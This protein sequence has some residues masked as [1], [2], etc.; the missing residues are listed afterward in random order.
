MISSCSMSFMRTRQVRILNTYDDGVANHDKR[1]K[2]ILLYYFTTTTH[3]NRP[4]DER[5]K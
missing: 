4:N 2:H 1:E 5:R 3:E